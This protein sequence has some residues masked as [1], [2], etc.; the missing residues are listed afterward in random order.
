MKQILCLSHS[1]WQARPNRTQQLLARLTDTQVLFFEPPASRGTPP[2]EQ[3]RKM[4]SHITVYTLPAPLLPGLERPA[5]QRRSLARAVSFIQKTMARH[6]FREPVLWCTFPGQAEFM[7]QI[8]Y[9]GLIYDCHREWGEEY[10]DQE[11]DLVSHAEVVFAASPG[12]VEQLSP[13]SDNIA[14]LPNGVNPMMF[15]RDE[16]TPPPLLSGL[17]GR[18]VFG[19]VG[20]LNSQ[21]ELEPLLYAAQAQP[22]WR[23]VLMGRVTKSVGAR[24]AQYPNIILTGPINAVEVPDC[25]SVC[26]V[27]FDL[28]RADRRGCDIIPAHIYE[29][30]ATGKPVVLMTEPEQVEPFPDVA[31][32]AYD[33]A[34]F[35]R[36]CR[37]ALDEAPDLASARRKDYA[38]QAS[39]ANR[40]AEV[41]RI[42]ESTG[43]F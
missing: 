23:F 39:W 33:P 7:D 40:A 10:L 22:D 41:S 3:G 34:G 6:R 4:R 32:T 25:L 28:I 15:A 43:L 8:A 27:L 13:C 5:L 30:L 42:L 24:L 31:Y 14:L 9:R 2:A 29:Y 26:S 16:F 17:D 19:R 11:S 20:D 21:V 18:P 12:L 1:P 36:R 38:A 37:R 35:L